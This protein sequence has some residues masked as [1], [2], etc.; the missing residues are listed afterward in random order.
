MTNAFLYTNLVNRKNRYRKRS[1]LLYAIE[2][3]QLRTVVSGCYVSQTSSY[4]DIEVQNREVPA[5][6]FKY[7]AVRFTNTDYTDYIAFIDRIEPN[8][9]NDITK[10][11]LFYRLYITIDWWSTI[12]LNDETGNDIARICRELEGN[13]ERAHVDDVEVTA[14]IAFADMKYTTD[15]PEVNIARFKRISNRIGDSKTWLYVYSSKRVIPEYTSTH[16]ISTPI[17]EIGDKE[18]RS[19]VNMYLC[20]VDG[21]VHNAS[22][23]LKRIGSDEVFNKRI[24]FL[25][26]G[27][28]DGFADSSIVGVYACNYMPFNIIDDYIDLTGGEPIFDT[29]D[30]A[31]YN[32]LHAIDFSGLGETNFVNVAAPILARKMPSSKLKASDYDVKTKAT[33][34]YTATPNSY[35]EYLTSITK[36]YFAPYTNVTVEKNNEVVV[37]DTAYIENVYLCEYNV[38]PQIS[39]FVLYHPSLR[40]QG[41]SAYSVII[42]NTRYERTSTNDNFT[43]LSAISS[44]LNFIGKAFSITGKT[45]DDFTSGTAGGIIGGVGNIPQAV[46]NGMGQYSKWAQ[47]LRDGED[48]TKIIN[49]SASNEISPLRVVK[50]EVYE[51]DKKTILKDL[52]LYGY[53]TYLHPHEVLTAHERKYFNYIKTNN[54]VVNVSSYSED[55][56]LSLEEMFNNGVWLWNDHIAF[57]NYEVPNYPIIMEEANV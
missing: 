19:A 50:T 45:V 9:F 12:M 4:V 20:C 30:G 47:I 55:I 22:Y 14:G 7:S 17:T 43:K 10:D 28:L 37:I 11:V 3:Y 24:E 5:L 41:E 25:S 46:S 49:N 52:A 26:T 42:D 54:A 40:Q 2:D 33:V 27:V 39:G 48:G 8:N 32:N 35:D 56:R 53:N 57:M 6:L 31:I 18:I 1:E 38:C 51:D 34:F 23:Q 29:S 15:L 21:D 44:S 36:Q 13:V 16:Y